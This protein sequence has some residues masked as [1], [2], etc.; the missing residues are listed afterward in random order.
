MLPML[1]WEQPHGLAI[2]ID[3]NGKNIPINKTN[4][5][6]SK[7]DIPSIPAGVYFVRV[8]DGKIFYL[9]NWFF[10]I[11]RPLSYVRLNTIGKTN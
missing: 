5:S 9:K 7:I 8:N 1:Y 3:A 10:K 11:E 6:T 2:L 4:K